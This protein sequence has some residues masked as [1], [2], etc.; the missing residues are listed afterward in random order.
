METKISRL[1]YPGLAFVIV[2]ALI[3]LAFGWLRLLLANVDGAAA[4][5]AD[6]GPT[7]EPPAT[8]GEPWHEDGQ[9]QPNDRRELVVEAEPEPYQ[10]QLPELGFTEYLERLVRIGT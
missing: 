10:Q 4:A 6:P 9:H 1:R 8:A 3:L 5:T 2:A 7:G